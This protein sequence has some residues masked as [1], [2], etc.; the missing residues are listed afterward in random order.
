MRLSAAQLRALCDDADRWLAADERERIAISAEA[1][2]RGNPF[3]E[4]FAAMI[5]QLSGEN[6]HGVLR[7]IPAAMRDAALA[8]ASIGRAST[9]LS[10]QDSPLSGEMLSAVSRHS[11][12]GALAVPPER[13]PGQLIGPYRLIQELGRGGMGVV[14]L[15]ER[16]DGQHTRQVALKMPL[17]ENL[18]WLLAA[19]FA[20]ERS[21]LASLEHPGIARL[22][23]AGVDSA[24]HSNQPFIAI[25]YVQGQ[26]ITAYV[27]DQKLKPEATVQ[28]FIKVIDAV[29]HAHTQLIIHRD[30]KPSNILVDARGE[31]HLLD[32]GI[33]KLLDNDSNT[34]EV[35]QLTKLSGRALTLDYASPEQINNA[36]LGTTSDVYS[37]GVVLY[38]LLTGTRPYHA[39][40]MS[41]RDLEQAILDQDPPKPS[42]QLATHSANTRTHTSATGKSAR[43]LRGDLDTIVLKAL[44]KDPRQR[45]ATAQAFAEDLRRCLAYEPIAAK[46]DDA[47]Y[48][49]T[50]FVRRHRLAVGFAATAGASLTVFAALIARE[51]AMHQRT[52]QF[53]LQALTPTSY[54][55]DGGGVLSHSELLKRA[56]DGVAKKF[57]DSPRAASELFDAIGESLFNLGA[58]EEA[59]QVRTRAQPGVD[60]A[61]GRTSREAV[62]NAGRATYMHLTQ[63]RFPEFLRSM[64]DLR[65]R[66]PS[67]DTLPV[68]HCYTYIWM[69]TQ[70]YAYT[71]EGHK[72]HAL[73]Q[74]YDARITPAVDA[75][76]RWHTLLNYWGAGGARQAGDLRAS[77]ARWQ[78]LLALP[79]TQDG[80]LGEH[81]TAL[82]ICLYLTEAGFYAD[83][84]RLSRE[85]YAQ[86]ERWM[87]ASFDPHLFYVP[88]VAIAQATAAVD[89][90]VEA[91]LRDGI[92]RAQA[93][94]GATVDQ[95]TADAREAL[96]LW[97]IARGRFAEAV[98]PLEHA[99]A[100]QRARGAAYNQYVTQMEVQ[101]A[102][103]TVLLAPATHVVIA[104]EEAISGLLALRA[105]AAAIPDRS[106][107]PRIDATLAGLERDT[108]RS[109]AHWQ[110]A[111]TAMQE[112]DLR[113]GDTALL[114]RAL[115]SERRFPAPV[116]DE[117]VASMRAYVTKVLAVTQ[118]EMSKR[119][120]PGAL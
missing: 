95:P 31:P 47:W 53:L 21:I 16:A 107:L 59:F 7:P 2:A 17:V 91:L 116:D 118:V 67:L 46:P 78:K 40:G 101:R 99:I 51:S 9:P 39:N 105:Q 35:T 22:Y 89:G 113:P 71:G 97:L 24:H 98:E 110:R 26:A 75:K 36:S 108:A 50:R 81:M 55:T 56:A 38:E 42:D 58:H 45:Y 111:V 44:R 29:A 5:E 43:R 72:R 106:T 62:R 112:S 88:G 76:S 41:R 85:V 94:T 66:C 32:F 3:A 48:R 102:V 80:A 73:W 64:D 63:R 12:Y 14:W 70:Y 4:A 27:R 69:Q 15:A 120:K 13:V 77:R 57:A 60:A 20:R 104:R 119:E 79:E 96:A 114:L 18:N 65:A 92:A 19:R 68:P 90:D 1:C 117:V 49:V 84:A 30:I 10:T 8:A 109:E 82:A 37:L 33:A 87:G 103:L 115:G 28:L 100:L 93:R 23:D 25:E 61:F 11:A 74:A 54:Y 86:G 34:L 52:T 6:D 83:A